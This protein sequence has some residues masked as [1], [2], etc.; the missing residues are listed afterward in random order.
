MRVL[1]TGAAGNLGALAAQY[2]LDHTT[3]QLNLMYHHKVIS[4]A[5]VQ[6]SRVT[7]FQCDLGDEQSIAPAIRNV[8]VII[9]FAG[10][11]FQASPEK[12][13]PTTNVE[14]FRNLVRV[15]KK[16]QIKKIILISFPHVEGNTTVDH[17]STNKLDQ[18]PVSVHAQT[19]LAEEKILL[20][21]IDTPVILRVG[22]V[23]GAGILMPDAARWF[24][25]RRLLCV[26]KEPTP[27]HVISKWDF[28]ECL[29]QATL[30]PTAR[31]TYNIGDDGIQTLQEFLDFACT[32]WKVRKPWRM[33]VQLIYFAASIFELVSKLFKVQSPL[34]NDFI[35]IGRVSYH[36][37]TSRMKQ[38]LLPTLKY[39]T[40]VE[41]KELF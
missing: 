21:E 3:A 29:V 34:T 40:I 2:F 12:F 17:P 33:P 9:H 16:S 38:E 27:I 19:R 39:S 41:G 20:N 15:A 14:Y 5:L 30:Q 7:A 31:G 28:C 22:M 6:N 13:L 18:M 26:W 36:G 24:A 32:Q 4:Q 11:L 25:R 37:D 35:D 1:I 10:K 8:D 23:Y